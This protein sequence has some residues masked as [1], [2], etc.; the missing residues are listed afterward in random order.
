MI[1]VWQLLLGAVIGGI[2]F[3]MVSTAR[4]ALLPSLVNREYLQNAV[5]FYA[6]SNN[7]SNIFAPSLAGALISFAKTT[8]SGF[9]LGAVG[10]AGALCSAFLLRAPKMEEAST[11][12][13]WSD[14]RTGLGYIRD[15]RSVLAVLSLVGSMAFF[16]MSYQ[17]MLPVLAR[18][19]YFVN[20]AELGVM[21]GS[22]GIGAI[23]GSVL[24][25]VWG[26][27][28]RRGAMA[29]AFLLVFGL[30][31][32]ALSLSRSVHLAYVVLPIIGLSNAFVRALAMALALHEVPDV[33]RGRVMSI[34]IMSFGLSPLGSL[35]M[36]ATAEAIN[37]PLAV[38]FGGAVTAFSALA[39][40]VF[41]P[42]L[43][44]LQ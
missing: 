3:A 2:A 14:L 44:R 4:T 29:I 34:Y 10:Y 5:A 16:G 13:V 28:P 17:S 12:S 40:A 21:M 39:I 41:I 35:V 33:L 1:T 32:V 22:V 19:V 23:I 15:H 11:E 42:E 25:T 18:Q 38:G 37:A 9:F 6:I 43:R 24:L 36:G 20:A 27:I 26:K 8:A 31:I 7:T 30:G